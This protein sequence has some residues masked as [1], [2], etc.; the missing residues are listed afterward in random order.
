[1]LGGAGFRQSTVGVPTHSLLVA[2]AKRAKNSKPR[3]TL[4][5]DTPKREEMGT[6]ANPKHFQVHELGK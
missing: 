1:M 4:K 5:G 6:T 3:D 2:P